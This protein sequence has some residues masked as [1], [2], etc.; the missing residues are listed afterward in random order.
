M[1]CE[2]GYEL[3]GNRRLCVN[4]PQSVASLVK[5]NFSINQYTCWQV[6]YLSHY[7]K[8]HQQ[9]KMQIYLTVSIQ[10]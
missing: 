6:E 5:D 1:L 10:I 4:S 9:E 3:K 2:P 7:V 8:R